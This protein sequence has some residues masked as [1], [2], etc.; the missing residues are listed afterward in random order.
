MSDADDT[1]EELFERE[2][3]AFCHNSRFLRS[4]L[5]FVIQIKLACITING[6]VIFVL[7]SEL[8]FPSWINACILI[9]GAI[10][11]FASIQMLLT[12]ERLMNSTLE[13]IKQLS[14][15]FFPASGPKSLL[16]FCQFSFTMTFCVIIFILSVAYIVLVCINP[17]LN[18]G[19]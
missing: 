16:N 9:G 17:W 1:N 12:T 13:K 7:G 10:V 19:I 2:K 8:N 15:A 18:E 14:P 3:L 6:A 11:N 4:L 5:K